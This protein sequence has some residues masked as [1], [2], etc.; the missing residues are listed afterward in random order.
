[1]PSAAVDLIGHAICLLPGQGAPL[2]VDLIFVLM[3][4]TYVAGTVLWL[5]DL[6][7]GSRR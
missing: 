5:R 6:A 4:I 2:V 3:V 7:F 1:M